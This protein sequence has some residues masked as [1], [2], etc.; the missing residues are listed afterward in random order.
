M[1]LIL[2]VV[3]SMIISYNIF[4]NFEEFCFTREIF[5]FATAPYK[6]D[7]LSVLIL[8]LGVRHSLFLWEVCVK[9][10]CVY[11]S[12]NIKVLIP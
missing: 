9:S 3:N 8:L 11:M 6:S 7:K 4:Y 5:F 12:P 10:L 1:N 2:K